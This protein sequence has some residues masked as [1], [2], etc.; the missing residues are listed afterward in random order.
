[1]R[2]LDDSDSD[3]IACLGNA[4]RASSE[5]VMQQVAIVIDNVL[6]FALLGVIR[7][8]AVSPS[9]QVPPLPHVCYFFFLRLERPAAFTW[10]LFD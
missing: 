5:A 7:A 9:I 10:T 4:E 3:S 6:S 1:M 2:E 8:S